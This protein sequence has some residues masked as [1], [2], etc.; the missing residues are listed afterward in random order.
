[1]G[2]PEDEPL[3]SRDRLID[4]RRH[5]PI[6]ESRGRPGQT[7]R[8]PYAEQ[9][10]RQRRLRLELLPEGLAGRS[11]PRAARRA[12]AQAAFLQPVL[13]NRPD[14]PDQRALDGRR[15]NVAA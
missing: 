8:P 5:S 7:R 4:S 12:G 6:A 1:M 14:P 3:V 15:G 9:T 10:T 13:R 2:S 11:N